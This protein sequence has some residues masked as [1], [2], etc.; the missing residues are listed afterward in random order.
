MALSF[1]QR[2]YFTSGKCVNVSF[3]IMQMF[4]SADPSPVGL[5]SL[6]WVSALAHAT[7]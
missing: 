7:H 4:T 3:F 2:E 6:P 5:L 1:K